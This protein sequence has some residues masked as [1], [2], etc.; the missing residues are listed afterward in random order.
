MAYTIRDPVV[1]GTGF[2]SDP[3]GFADTVEV[4]SRMFDACVVVD[5]SLSYKFNDGARVI[6]E[7][8]PEDAL[9]TVHFDN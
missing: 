2:N 6:L 8:H 1:F 5:G 4:T 7:I 9:K 3:R